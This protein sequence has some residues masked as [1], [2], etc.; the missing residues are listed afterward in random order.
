MVSAGSHQLLLAGKEAGVELDAVCLL[1]SGV[2]PAERLPEPPQ[3][4][5]TRTLTGAVGDGVAD[6]TAVLVAAFAALQP[7]DGL[8]IPAGRYRFTTPLSLKTSSVSLIGVDAGSILFADLPAGTTA[9]ALTLAGGFETGST[10][11]LSDA[12]ALSHE[13][14][15]PLGASFAVGDAVLVSS[16]EWG[17]AAPNLTTLFFRNR[18]NTAHVVRLRDEASARVLVLDRPLLGPFLLA[19]SAKVERFVPLKDV[20]LQRVSVDGPNR[21][22][23]AD[24]PDNDLIEASRC[25]RCFFADLALTHF[26]V[27]GLDTFR[28]VD[29]NVV[30]VH[31]ASATDTGGGGHGYGVTINRAQGVVIRDSLFDGVMRHGVPISWGARESFVFRNV[32]DRRAVQAVEKLASID[33]HGQDDYANLVEGNLIREG[34]PGIVVGGGGTTH[35]N[36]GPFNVVRGNEIQDVTDGVAI[37]KSTWSTVVERNLILRPTRYGVRVESNSNSTFVWGNAISGWTIAGVS[38]RDATGIDVRANDFSPGSAVAVRIVD[39]GGYTVR[40]NV[41]R[42]GGVQHPDAGDVGGNF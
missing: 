3:R 33:I 42:D 2:I 27:S 35:G 14:S 15:V 20:V 36:D 39:G 19:H 10:S 26:R 16:D 8:L 4:A 1:P 29:L 25:D 23:Q 21:A 7:G 18:A 32:F 11:L 28:S 5:I 31:A 6:D 22:V 37:Y 9:A 40:D 17:P 13:I 12:P 34:D 24:N 30:R 41:L 38:S